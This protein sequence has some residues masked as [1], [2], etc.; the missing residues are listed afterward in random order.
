MF[1]LNVF[2]I[3]LRIKSDYE[4]KEGLLH[5]NKVETVY[6]KCILKYSRYT[7]SFEKC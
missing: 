6:R 2:H 1:E 5:V 3:L 4:P 7:K